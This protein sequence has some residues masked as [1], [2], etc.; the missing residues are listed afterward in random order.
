MARSG[1]VRDIIC[2]L[3]EIGLFFEIKSGDCCNED[4]NNLS[5]HKRTKEEVVMN[6][7]LGKY[8]KVAI[9]MGFDG[10][11]VEEDGRL[12]LYGEAYRLINMEE[13]EEA[14]V[15][16]E[17]MDGLDLDKVFWETSDLEESVPAQMVI[18][19]D[20]NFFMYGPDDCGMA[21]DDDFCGWLMFPVQ[22][23]SID[24]FK[25]LFPLV[26]DVLGSDLSED[27][28]A[29]RTKELSDFLKELMIDDELSNGIK[30]E[31][32]IE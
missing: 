28:L 23:R 2:P 11:Y 10:S 5:G 27:S 29:S 24:D 18:T 12:N 17:G 8:L 6:E 20:H 19:E 4:T 9:E 25:K 7:L 26:V 15:I 1:D 30:I 16:I 31:D 21:W 32:I 13:P 22:M 14:L 3:P